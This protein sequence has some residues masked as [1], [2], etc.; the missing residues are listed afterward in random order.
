M[1]EH[2]TIL[3]ISDGANDSNPL[4][5]ALKETGCDVVKAASPAQGVALLYVM[6]TLTAVV[7]DERLREHAS[8]DVVQSLTKIR[9][10][11]PVMLQC[12]NEIGGPLSSME[13]CLST[14]KL[15][16]ELQHL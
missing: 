16:S 14:D 5:A 3:Y 2:N 9:P 6:H 12:D 8:F 13:G 4:L 10:S 1:I 11:V 7:L 15:T